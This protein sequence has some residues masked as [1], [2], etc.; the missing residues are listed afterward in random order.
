MEIL[1]YPGPLP[2]VTNA[3]LQQ[4]RVIARDY[5]NRRIGDFL[6]ELKLTEGKATGFPL[7]K[8]EMARNGSPEPVFYTDEERTLFLVTLPCHPELQVTKSG[9]KSGPKLIREEVDMILSKEIDSEVLGIL[10]DYDISEVRDYV[11]DQLVNMSLTK[12]VTKSVTKPVT[13]SVTKLIDLIDFFSEERSR[14]ELFSFLE[15]GNQTKNFNT[16]IKPLLENRILEMTLPDKP[17]S[18]HQKYRLTTKGKQL[19]K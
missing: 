7:I 9:P 10:L 17:N 2:P 1:S 8:D 19:L 4:R 14:E 3:A 6:K 12:A 18:Q 15:I 16:N 5:R 11:R 13:K